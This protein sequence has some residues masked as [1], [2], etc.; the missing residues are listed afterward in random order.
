[1]VFGASIT[2]LSRAGTLQNVKLIPNNDIVGAG[3]IYSLAFQAPS[4]LPKDGKILLYFPREFDISSVS[5]A[6]NSQNLT[7]GFIVR[8]DSGNWIVTLERDGTGADLAPLDSG[9]VKFSIVGNP[10]TPGSYGFPQI[11]TQDKNGAALDIRIDVVVTIK[12][13]PL[14]HFAF[15][16]TINNQIA[17]QNF[18]FTIFGKDKFD[19]NVVVNDSIL[20]SDHTS[21]LTPKRVRMNNVP[22]LTVAAKITK[23]QS[24]VKITATAKTLGK[25]GVSNSFN[26][27]PGS[28][29]TF[30]LSSVPNTLVAGAPLTLTM[31]AQDA[32][33]NTVT[34]FNGSV[35]F[36]PN[37]EIQPA[38]SG[39]FSNG[40]LSETIAYLKSGSNKT[41]IVNDGLGHSGVSNSFTVTPSNPSGRITFT[42]TPKAIPADRAT[43]SQVSSVGPVQDAYGNNVGGGKLFSVSVNDTALG[44]I[45]TPDADP[46]TPGQQIVTSSS[47]GSVG[48]LGFTFKAGG[49]GGAATIF[50]SS[51]DGTAAGS[52][53]IS[54]NQVKIQ[55]MATTPATVSQGQRNIPVKM[56]VQNFGAD[57]VSIDSA[58]LSF[59]RNASDFTVK[60]P[61]PLPKIPGNT[62]RTLTFSVSVA[63]NA[64]IGPVTIDGR[65]FGKLSSNIQY[66][67][68]NAD[69]TAAWTV[70]TPAKL[71][72]SLKASQATV[73]QRQTQPWKVTMTVHN[74]GQS[75]VQVILRDD[76]TR[77]S[78]AAAG[79]AVSPPTGP[80]IIAGESAKNMDFVVTATSD[81][82]KSRQ[83]IHG[84]VYAREL[85]SDS[86]HFADTSSNGSAHVTVQ[87]PARVVLDPPVLFEV[88]NGDTVNVGQKFLIKTSVKQ[89]QGTEKVDSVRVKLANFNGNNAA[90]FKD[91]VVLANN[92]TQSIFFELTANNVAPK[93]AQFRANIV[94]A[95]S[96]N[97]GAN[98]VLF[99]GASKFVE[100][101]IQQKGNLQFD[102]ITTS[103][104]TVR[105]G[106]TAPWTITIDVSNSAPLQA[107]AVVIDST[108]FT[109]KAG[110]NVQRDYTVEKVTPD[111]LLNAG[112]SKTLLFRVTKTGTT[113]G[114]IT[115]TATVHAHHKNSREKITASR[116][117]SIIVESTALVTIAKTSF[118]AAVNRVAG[119]DI[120][121]VDTG[122]VF[123]ISVTVRN[124]GFEKVAKA[125][126]TLSTK[127]RS[128][129]INRQRQTGPID[130]ESGTAV[131]TFMV[132]AD[133]A[134]NN[135]GEIFTARLDSA[136]NE[137]GNH[138]SVGSALDAKDTTAIVRLELPARLQLSLMTGD[139]STAFSRGQQ[140]KL[141][142][143]VK[144][145]GHAQ[146]DQSG[147]LQLSFSNNNYKLIGNEPSKKNFAG[148]DSVEWNLQ[149]PSNE[150]RQD[151]FVVRMIK[152][153]IAK[154]SGQPADTVNATA[155]LVVS[156]L[157]NALNI[158]D[159]FVL[160]PAGA[161]D[162]TISTNQ[163][164][165]VAVKIQAS[166]NLSNKTA[167][168]TLPA[169]SGYRFVNGDSA[170]KKVASDTVSWLV[171]APSF[172]NLKPFKL[173]LE[174]KAFDRQQMVAARDTLVILATE[175]QAILQLEPGIKEAG[176]QDG[177]VSSN[178]SFTIVAKLRNTGRASV[179]GAVEVTIRPP[180]TMTLQEA[181][182]KTAVFSPGISNREVTW[183]VKA[184][185]QPTPPNQQ[186]RFAL[187]ITQRPRDVNSGLEVLTSN[188]PAQ[189]DVKIVETGTLFAAPPRI[190]APDGAKDRILST[191][192]EFTI[193][194]SLS[195]TNAANLTAELIFTPNANFTVFN[196]VQNV[197]GANKTG[198]I[199][200]SWIIRAPAAPVN[201][202]N[203]RVI[204]K[205]VD[206]HNNALPLLH[207]SVSIAIN[208]MQRA[209]LSLNA[210][211]AEPASAANGIV[212][213]GQPFKVVATIL[214]A[215]ATG[216]YDTAKVQLTLPEGYTLIDTQKTLLKAAKL[217]GENTFAWWVRARADISETAD[218][219][220]F[221]LIQ[222]PR[223]ENTDAFAA[224]SDDQTEL[225]VRAEGRKLVV[226]DL[227]QGGGPAVRGGQNVL[228]ARLQLLNPARP[229]ASDLMLKRLGFDVLNRAG[230][231]LAPNS[232][233]KAVRVIHEKAPAPI[234]CGENNSLANN[235]IVVALS[236]GVSVSPD[237]PDTIAIVAD[238]I[239]STTEKNF[240]LLF[241]DSQ[242]FEVEDQ[243]GGSG[244]V[245]ETA[246]GRRG[247]KFRLESNLTSLHGA[248]AASA[249]F[250]YPN[251]LQPG[252]DFSRG[253]GT[254]FNLPAGAS[255]ELKIFT[256]L[257]EL[258]WGTTVQARE[259]LEFQG[260]F[261]NGHNGAGK[262]VLNGVYLAVLKT[263]DGKMV[264][265]KVAV[266][267]K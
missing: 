130:T 191:G 36:T 48:R 66:S 208:V 264:T 164:F 116:A 162:R 56:R 139:G 90:I 157:Q 176:A 41:I 16:S 3:A 156:T 63:P 31:T 73:T 252:E 6:S 13:G 74:N 33:G 53:N 193:S 188:D 14:D 179:D 195:W 78:L 21:T 30:L 68:T 246:D 37:G 111:S 178:Q 49:K 40:V 105:F 15:S 175:K 253:E 161:R 260:I 18:N 47:V 221:K 150:S 62:I 229:G 206:A 232:L 225:T 155:Q 245:V 137:F 163:I 8:L 89:T 267:K 121:L 81:T 28:L 29:A 120:A 210:Q 209:E 135:V 167:T 55:A 100:A 249:F 34:S 187:E 133:A 148:G 97:T 239:E 85:N 144:N 26:V 134:V 46:N 185:S 160:A 226:E 214:N 182:K 10:T 75:A 213:I 38:K 198:S 93:K 152:R 88:Y 104:N 52:V 265:T 99:D 235:P 136:K 127:G 103:E 138:I 24:D 240:R 65:L 51:L 183:Q 131:A 207:Q 9:R 77:T 143:L 109:F 4:G 50:V 117:T 196:P 92:L 124:T 224:I 230:R 106:R 251:P 231:P 186:E 17:G 145:L 236:T 257:G 86:L 170:T 223:D 113:S 70:Q 64:Q 266:L 12:A 141:R 79:H 107:G 200:V 201:D 94:A 80:I 118:P 218:L 146:T 43:T 158:Q 142:A 110:Q 132:K 60:A 149:A 243:A 215:A 126:V 57:T 39:N 169:G 228:L 212:G 27:A 151:V 261:W 165:T 263:N 199:N 140:F 35:N 234:P 197:T 119:T 54:V 174:A 59:S 250:N 244:V 125:W 181:P 71:S 190:T 255:G 45:T 23:A 166:S 129:I 211:I 204:F 242:D 76:S 205:A 61:T 5:V 172:E 2:G 84:Q 203:A 256:M 112:K 171:Q 67:D 238:L 192:Q 72:V 237:K 159:K 7:G 153:P 147:E 154:N 98:T 58:K 219:L 91:E 19:N 177:L 32:S 96:A 69:T 173:P 22:S 122:Q 217:P 262:R 95:Y 258:V 233:F 189:L 42:A 11:L 184:A 108:V 222:P 82:A 25:S 101:Y 216:V 247:N 259:P 1:M 248:D 254:R 168:L 227:R 128:K 83:T 114:A 194:D 44:T 115:I 241:D 20:F 87:K 123:P 102:R 180:S 220:K 202:I